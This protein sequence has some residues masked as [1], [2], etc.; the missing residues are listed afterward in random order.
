MTELEIQPGIPV[1]LIG[2]PERTGVIAPEPCK[3]VANGILMARVHFD[4]TT[5]LPG[6]ERP[7][8]NQFRRTPIRWRNSESV[9]FMAW[10]VFN[11]S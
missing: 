10:P 6:N 9:R 2:N 4:G 1:R 7:T 11:A 3:R 5:S 8:S